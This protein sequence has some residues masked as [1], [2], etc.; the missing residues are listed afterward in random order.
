MSSFTLSAFADE[1]D[2]D[3]DTQIRVLKQHK[4]H[5]IEIRGVNGRS[6]VDHTIQEVFALKAK[7]DSNNIKV[8]AIGSP[9]GKIK[10]TDDFSAHMDLFNHIIK[11]AK[12]LETKYIRIFSFYMPDS[13]NASDHREEVLRR[14]DVL[15]RA[16]T[17][18]DLILLHENEK[19]IYGDTAERCLDLLQAINSKYLRAVFDPANF[20]QCGEVPYPD[21]YD[22]L[23]D[24]I[25]YMHIKDALESDGSNVPAGEGDGRIEII[26]KQLNESGYEGILAL[27]PHL[28]FFEGLQDLELDKKIDDQPAGDGEAKFAV[29]VDA[30]CKITQRLGITTN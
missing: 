2:S 19:G 24:Y 10:I 22:M 21:A 4:I 27:E 26:L 5:N 17:E 12:V 14:L 25:E 23:R 29:A 7:L 9:V 3:F 11:I 18:N 15:V 28:T 20:L 6:I 1:I 16:A 8:A 30:L 13:D